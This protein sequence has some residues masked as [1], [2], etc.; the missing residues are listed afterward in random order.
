MVD[1][2]GLYRLKQSLSLIKEEFVKL[3]QQSE[4]KLASSAMQKEFMERN[5]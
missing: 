4:L 5:G 2:R 1:E 3:I